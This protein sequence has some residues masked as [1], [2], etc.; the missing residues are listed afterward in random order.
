MREIAAKDERVKVIANSRNF[1]ASRSSFNGLLRS[2]GDA[3]VF[4]IAADLQ[5]PPSMIPEFVKKW[6]EGYEVVYGIRSKRQE[7]FVMTS[8]R[9]FYYRLMRKFVDFDI[10]ADVG[11]FQLIDKVIVNAL[12]KFDD[13]CPYVRGLIAQCGFRK[14]GIK[15]QHLARKKGRTT[16]GISALVDLG[17]NGIIS[18]TNFPLRIAMLAGLSI[19]ILSITYAFIEL[20]LGLIFFRRFVAPGIAT[21]IVSIFFFSGIQLFFLGV[22]GEY[23][24][25]IHSQVRKRPLVIERETI[26]FD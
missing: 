20:I 3:V 10:P 2:K 17:L 11:D 19:S 7:N 12:R 4:T 14:I 8:V 5:D 21:I 26:N 23:I 15:Y 25:A 1:G 16:G 22:I 13:Y 6:K 9:K 18:F 24:G